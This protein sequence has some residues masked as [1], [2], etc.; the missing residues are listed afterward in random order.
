MRNERGTT[1]D[2]AMLL[3]VRKERIIHY[4]LKLFMTWGDAYFY[5][6]NLTVRLSGEKSAHNWEPHAD[7]FAF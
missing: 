6:K 2:V 3:Y 7:F 4:S 5:I 1:N